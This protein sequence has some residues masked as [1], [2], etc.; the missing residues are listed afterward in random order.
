VLHRGQVDDQVTCGAE[1]AQELVAQGGSWRDAE[2]PPERGDDVAAAVCPGGK[3]EADIIATE[4]V[5]ALPIT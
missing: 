5:T 2:F 1:Q 3:A 4:C